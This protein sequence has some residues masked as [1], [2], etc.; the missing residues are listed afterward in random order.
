MTQAA[1][2]AAG[3]APGTGPGQLSAYSPHAPAVHQDTTGP[4][5]GTGTFNPATSKLV[6]S[7]ATATSDLY[8][9]ADGSYTR[10]VSSA[11]LN[12][13]T[14]SGA[15]A[16]IDT[17]LAVQSDG[18]WH[19]RANSLA[20]S[21]ATRSDDAALGSLGGTGNHGPF[22]ISFGLAG[23]ARVQGTAAGPAMTYPGVLPATDVTEADTAAGIA[24]RL[25]LHSATAPSTWIFPLKLT[26][27][28]PALQAD[29]SVDLL[30]A[31]G[32]VQGVIPAGLARDS[33]TGPQTGPV[34]ATTPVTYQLIT[35]HGGPALQAS[36]DPAWLAS[37]AR[38]FPVTVD[39]S[40]NATVTGTTEAMYPFTNDY[41]GN[42]LLQ[43]GTYD[44]GSNYARSFL[45]FNGLGSAL[46][47]EHITGASL[48]VWDA[49]AW[50]CG[51]AEPF[52][53]NEIT[54]SWSVTGNKSWPGPSTGPAWASWTPPRR[55]PRA[56]TP[57]GTRRSAAG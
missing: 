48:H 35:Y 6:G 10:I 30:D 21:F 11:P 27:L 37:P 49:W 15:W 20:V 36:I 57:A 26:G 32:A 43:V 4:A 39:P 23:A 54:Q 53:A 13:Q 19:N 40:Y 52:W 1:S 5:P 47:N 18:R 2:R 41:S 9:N 50:T 17:S 31:S 46:A 45:A 28:T 7:A 25:V 51:T 12:Y 34:G 38:V 22:G 56:R 29:G 3:R 14:S 8:Q 16:P 44:S 42:T 33:A 55:R 24:E